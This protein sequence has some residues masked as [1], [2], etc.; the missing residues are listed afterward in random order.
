MRV[1]LPDLRE[2][3]PG[4]SLRAEDKLIQEPVDKCSPKHPLV[5]KSRG[6]EGKRRVGF[7]V[8]EIHARI[9]TCKTIQ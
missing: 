2:A 5:C 4:G 8:N 6:L 9:Q 3:L 1:T 7:I